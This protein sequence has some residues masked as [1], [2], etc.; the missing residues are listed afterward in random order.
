MAKPTI[1]TSTSDTSTATTAP[2][3]VVAGTKVRSKVLTQYTPNELIALIGG[4][5]KV[6]VSLKE[7][8][9][10]V[11]KAKSDEILAS[12]GL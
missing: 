6:G 1:V 4:D 10:I 9:V 8:K 2:V 3:A 7:L 12:V 11:L 5:T